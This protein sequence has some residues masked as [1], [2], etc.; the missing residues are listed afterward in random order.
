MDEAT[1]Q[2]ILDR[3]AKGEGL[4]TILRTMDKAP[5]MIELRDL[6]GFKQRYA[7]A[8]ALAGI[9]QRETAQ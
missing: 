1:L 4:E 8:K 5:S 3:A 9:D 2:A 6:P 7:A